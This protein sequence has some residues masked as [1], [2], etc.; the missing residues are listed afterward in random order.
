MSAVAT[1]TD[2]LT[3]FSRRHRV[4][5]ELTHQGR[6]RQSVRRILVR[7]TGEVCLHFQ[8]KHSCVRC[9]AYFDSQ[10]HHPPMGAVVCKMPAAHL[11]LSEQNAALH[12]GRF[13]APS[14]EH[15]LWHHS[16]TSPVIKTWPLTM[17]DHLR[18][19][20]L[21]VKIITH[22]FRARYVTQF[23]IIK[24]IFSRTY[25]IKK[26]HLG[27]LLFFVHHPSNGYH[28]SPRPQLCDL[29]HIEVPVRIFLPIRPHRR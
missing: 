23:W 29:L 11:Q 14:V 4:G 25:F 27:V 9:I 10:I 28:I 26:E 8:N 19:S 7:V 18:I 22:Q 5:P 3:D 15:D 16:D 21:D 17:E 1:L 24:L 12:V 13:R 2:V 6:W 20:R